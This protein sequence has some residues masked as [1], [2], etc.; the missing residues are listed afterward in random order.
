M[1]KTLLFFAILTSMIV[2]SQNNFEKGYF[3]NNS[4]VKTEC[5]IRNMGWKSNPT[6]FEYKVDLNSESETGLIKNVKLFEIPSEVKFVRADVQIDRSSRNIN[7]LSTYSTLSSNEETL[8]LQEIVSGEAVLYRYAEG[9]LT[10]FF[11]QIKDE[12]IKQLEYK[13]FLKQ[14]EELEPER[15]SYNTNYK[16]QLKNSL[17]CS[18]ITSSDI[19]HADYVTRDLEK[20]FLKFNQ[21]INPN[22][23]QV[24]TKIK[25]GDF[26]LNIRPRVNFASVKLDITNLPKPLE[27][28]TNTKFSVGLEFEYIFAFYN[29]KLALIIEPNYQEYKFEEEADVD[30]LSGKKIRGIVDYKTIE[31][32]VGLRYYMFLN[33]QSKLFIN[34]SAVFDGVM[35]SKVEFVR[36]DGSIFKSDKIRMTKPN[37][38]LGVG[39]NYNK[40]YA[41]EARYFSPR[42]LSVETFGSKN[43]YQNFS[44]ILSYNLF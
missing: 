29:H 15:I 21:C 17:H 10:R 14:R 40:K 18:T 32:P 6:S 35:N 23:T 25:K 13:V 28:E 11:Y 1:N 5:F 20:L 43:T 39:Y 4:D 2:F 38:A 41:I 34:A 12:P 26:N 22:N 7:Q 9:T 24:I 27:S 16:T 8:F 36:A 42:D 3:I 37:I 19:D 44:L 31:I 30:F 33:E